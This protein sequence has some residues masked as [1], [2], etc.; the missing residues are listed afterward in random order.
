M[1]SLLGVLLLASFV[2]VLHPW[3]GWA[4]VAV[5]AG[6]GPVV[7]RLA[8]GTAPRAY[9]GA[10]DD[11]IYRGERILVALA[12]V[13]M[14]AAVFVDVVWRTIH[15]VEGR[16]AYGFLL[17]ILALCLIG[18]FTA[19]WPGAGPL[20]RLGA[21]LLAFGGFSAFGAAVASAPTGFGWSQ[22]LA[23]VLIL[24]VG[25]LGSSMAT[26]EGRHIA[27]DAVKRV[28]PERLRR[29]FEVAAALLTV[30]LTLVLMLLA[31]GYA[32][33]NFVDWLQSDMKAFL[34]ES[35]EAPYWAASV[36]IP[37]GFGLMAARFFGVVL[38]G[39]KEVDLLTSVGAGP[40]EKA[41]AKA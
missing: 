10:L 35:L 26:K 41:E 13:V 18:G 38:Y 30:A 4:W 6:V 14:A 1:K 12:L 21:G 39:A 23:L 24:W 28:V 22:R 3:A 2:S 20:K 40:G 25:M 7:A 33:G 5:L 31:V 37:I 17:G 29:G 32:R 9:F 19:R 34:F 36:P 15:S 27:V 11:L 16:T 8:R